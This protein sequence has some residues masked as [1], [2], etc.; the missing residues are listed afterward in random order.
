VEKYRVRPRRPASL[1][2]RT[3]LKTHVM[4]LVALDF[5]TVPTVDFKVLFVLVIVA[6]ARRKVVHFNVTAYP[7]AQ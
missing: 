6:H 4:E 7:T 2:W 1:A 3:F 5:F